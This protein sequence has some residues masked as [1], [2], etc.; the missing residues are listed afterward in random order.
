MKNVIIYSE[1][2][3]S[4]SVCVNKNFTVKQ[5]TDEINKIHP[6]GIKS[7]WSLSKNKTFRTGEL[8]GCECNEHPT[9]RKHY[10]FNC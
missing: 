2:I 5:I 1:G 10:L 3:C 6:T 9:K 8:N 7:K 4:L